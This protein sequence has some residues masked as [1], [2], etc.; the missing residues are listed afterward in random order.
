MR[1]LVARLLAVIAIIGGILNMVFLG[2]QF[3]FAGFLTGVVIL[4]IAKPVIEDML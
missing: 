1:S 4:W 3:G 2:A